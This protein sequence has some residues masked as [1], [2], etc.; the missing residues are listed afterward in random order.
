[1]IVGGGYT[2]MWAAWWISEREPDASIVLLEADRCGFG[3]SGRNGGFVNSMWFSLPTM[4]AVFGDERAL[5]IA[6]AAGESI[7]EIGEWCE[8]QDVDAWFTHGGYLQA[9]TSSHFDASWGPIAEACDELGAGDMVEPLDGE[10]IASRCAS[11]LFRSAAFYPQAATVQPARLVK[12]LRDRLL[13]PASG[14]TRAP[15]SAR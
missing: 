12:G 9:S 10:G 8:Q 3:P 15:R 6:R 14:S 11:P 1:M 7:G 13:A 5:A 2:G 4:R